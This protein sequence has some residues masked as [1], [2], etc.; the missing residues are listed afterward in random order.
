M[1]HEYQP[2]S[3]A[4]VHGSFEFISALSVILLL[5][6]FSSRC[7]RLVNAPASGLGCCTRALDNPLQMI[8]DS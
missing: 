7:A 5:R 4:I 2:R 1:Q 8:L 3:V 6:C